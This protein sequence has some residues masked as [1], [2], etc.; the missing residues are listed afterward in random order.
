MGQ[1]RRPGCA[2]ELPATL[3]VGVARYRPNLYWLFCIQSL[4]ALCSFGAGMIALV[5]VLHGAAGLCR[6]DILQG[7][8]CESELS[9][10]GLW[11]QLA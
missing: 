1:I 4:I 5:T 2:D 6:C 7:F 9:L 11:L 8:T 3:E 10:G